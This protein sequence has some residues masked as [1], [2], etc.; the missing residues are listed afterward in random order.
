MDK[1]ILIIDGFET[2]M[3]SYYIAIQKSLQL[4]NIHFLL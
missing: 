4:N 1:E 2:A 3:F